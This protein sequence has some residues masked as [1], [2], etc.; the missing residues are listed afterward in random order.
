MSGTT[1]RQGQVVR[2]RRSRLPWLLWLVGILLIVIWWALYQSRWFLIEDIKVQGVKRL[3]QARVIQLADV[4]IGQPLISANP[5][6]ISRRLE[7]ITQIKSVQVERGWPHSVLL[8]VTERS[9][10]AVS[11]AKSGLNLIDDEGMLAGTTA[12]KPKRMRIIFAKPNSAAMKSAVQ[13]ALA[14]PQTWKVSK[15]TAEYP[16]SVVATLTS[17]ETIIFGSG[18]QARLKVRVARSLLFNKFTHINVS[19]PTNP[20]LRK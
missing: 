18:E 14:I 15:I 5:G 1:I 16:N 10:V 9:P 12:K 19:T 3:N 17:G 7:K 8:K 11:V 6:K 4:Q 13:I 20:T 2:K